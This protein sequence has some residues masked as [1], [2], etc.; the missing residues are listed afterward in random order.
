MA[1]KLKTL[2]AERSLDEVELKKRECTIKQYAEKIMN[3][4]ET[5]SVFHSAGKSVAS[6]SFKTEYKAVADPK[7]MECAPYSG[8]DSISSRECDTDTETLESTD[9]DS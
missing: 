6:L 2:Y 4:K 3:L 8:D 5:H 7:F 1:K 9:L